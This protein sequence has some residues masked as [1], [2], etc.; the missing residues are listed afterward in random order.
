MKGDFKALK[1]LAIQALELQEYDTAVELWK[2]AIKLNENDPDVFLNMGYAFLKLEKYQEALDSS[3]RA[4]ELDPNMKEAV[5]NYAGCEF[6][7]GD[8][9]NYNFYS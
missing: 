3:R 4:M 8:I 6:L 2:E 5:L 7:I 1:E 9:G